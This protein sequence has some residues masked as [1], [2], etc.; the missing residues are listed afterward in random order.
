MIKTKTEDIMDPKI[1]NISGSRKPYLETNINPL[2]ANYVH[3]YRYK[4]Y[5][6]NRSK[7]MIVYS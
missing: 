7:M 5:A 3:T 2:K 1:Y 6:L 4:E